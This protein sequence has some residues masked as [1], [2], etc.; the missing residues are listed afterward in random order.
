MCHYSQEWSSKWTTDQKMITPHHTYARVWIQVQ[1]CFI[2]IG[3]SCLVGLTLTLPQWINTVA[4]D[5]T[6]LASQLI[7]TP[8]F[9]TQPTKGW[10]QHQELRALLFSI[11]VCVFFLTSPANHTCVTLKMQEKRPT[12]YSPYL[13]RLKPLTICRC[14]I[15]QRQHI[16]FSY[17]KTPSVGARTLDLLHGRLADWRS[18]NWANQAAVI[19]HCHITLYLTELCVLQGCQ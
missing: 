18:T 9:R 7:L 16:L 1:Y 19:S 8:L 10:P 4:G 17:F 15:S 14:K 3:T 13:R 2:S 6:G 12:I 11:N 5:E